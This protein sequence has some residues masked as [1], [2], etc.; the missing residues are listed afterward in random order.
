MNYTTSDPVLFTKNDLYGHRAR[1]MVAEKRAAIQTKI[2]GTCEPIP[3]YLAAVNPKGVYPF[4][5]D[6]NLVC[7]GPPLDELLH[8][9]Y[10]APAL[11]PIDPSLRAR[12]RMLCNEVV[13]WYR[14]PP[15]AIAQKLS[16][17]EEVYDPSVKFL[18]GYLSIVDIAIAP[19]LYR[20]PVKG[21][22]KFYAD[23]VLTRPSFD[24][25]LRDNIP[26][27]SDSYLSEVAA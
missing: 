4:L 2:I 20:S 14:L 23:D 16:E 25:S 3:E 21:K 8:E 7:H 1:L 26:V 22:L 12:D 6:K 11:I 5:V 13:R 18:F 19:L 10:P 27:F 24:I 9:R 15:D 17:V